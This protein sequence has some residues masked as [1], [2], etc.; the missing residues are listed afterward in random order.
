[1]SG[2]P[3]LLSLEEDGAEAAIRR[4]LNEPSFVIV[5]HD[6]KQD[7]L[8][9]AAAGVSV[10]GKAFDLMVA[11][12]LLEATS[13]HSL[14]ELASRYLGARL[15][16]FRAECD[17][18]VAGMTVMQAVA[19]KMEDELRQAGLD[20]LFADVEMPLVKVLTRIERHGMLIDVDHLRA[21]SEEFSQRLGAL[22]KDIHLLAGEEFNI[23]SP[24]QLRAVLFDKLGL[25]KKGVRKG[26]TGYSTDVDVLT[27]LAKEHP[28]PEKILAYRVLSKLK[29]TYLDALPAAVNPASGR[30]HTSLNQ[31]VAATGR[32]SSSDPN[33]QNIPIR[34]EE[35]RRIR[36]AFVAPP[37]HVLLAADYSQ[38][39]L[40]VLAHLS[41]DPAL[42][43]AFRSGEDVHTRTAAEVFGV[44]P[45][46][47]SADQRRAAKVINFGILYG[48]GPQRL[49][50]ELGIPIAEAQ[51]YIGN[52][53][54][55][56]A[57]VRAF[58]NQVIE[59]GRERGYVKTI[60]G[61]RRAVPELRST[62]RGVAQAAERVAGNTPIQ[63]SAADIIKL[64]MVAVDRRVTA[65]KLRAALLLQVHDELLLEVHEADREA[66]GEVL[67]E[68]MEGALPLAVPLRVDIG[69]GRSWAEAH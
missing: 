36:Q 7:F 64:A 67:R 69:F 15:A 66:T 26:K 27:R 9:L 12:Y 29:S 21:M 3:A 13:T 41:Q 40:R 42:V 47:V 28:L 55:R 53:F 49:A 43:E 54:A 58:M 48:M 68:E 17:T 45:G 1:V 51:R 25:S 59:E 30:L 22:M 24:P 8:R 35:G 62:E 34:G 46:L 50:Q 57:G 14:E 61:R 65:L 5:G 38:I 56:Y 20:R 11:S 18:A 10:G 32:L 23:N 6:L 33:L 63:G 37:Q 39:E 16:G 4:A 52:Y 60:L 2:P 44:L 19:A 31:T